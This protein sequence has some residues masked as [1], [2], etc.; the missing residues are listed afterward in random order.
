MPASQAGHLGCYT[1]GDK[2]SFYAIDL[3]TAAPPFRLE[4]LTAPRCLIL[5]YGL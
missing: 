4:C 3:T 1:A 2:Y 5:R